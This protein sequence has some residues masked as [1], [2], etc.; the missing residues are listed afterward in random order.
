MNLL[1]NKAQPRE[2]KHG[3]I[4]EL[5]FHEK[6]GTGEKREGVR[7]RGREMERESSRERDG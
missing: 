4:N 7:L 2:K 3:G 6:E 5:V 1:V